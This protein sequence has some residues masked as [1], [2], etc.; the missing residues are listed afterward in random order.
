MEC[1]INGRAESKILEVFQMAE[2]GKELPPTVNA[3]EPSVENLI[4]PRKR[5]TYGIVEMNRACG[6]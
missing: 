5:S 4:I 6:R 2:D 1:I 3:P